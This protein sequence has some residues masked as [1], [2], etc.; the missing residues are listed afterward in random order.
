M[1]DYKFHSFDQQLTYTPHEIRHQ[2]PDEEDA[3]L[4]LPVAQQAAGL[5]R[6]L[7]TATT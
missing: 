5:D 4:Y 6:L 1:S 2:V 3:S 7:A